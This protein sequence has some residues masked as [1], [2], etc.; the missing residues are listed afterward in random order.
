MGALETTNRP[1]AA[2]GTGGTTRGVLERLEVFPVGT[3]PYFQHEVIPKNIPKVDVWRFIN[4]LRSGV[5]R[6]EAED[7]VMQDWRRRF[8]LGCVARVTGEL[9]RKGVAPVL[10]VELVTAW[11]G[12]HFDL[13]ADDTM[14]CI[15]WVAQRE[16]Q[17]RGGEAG[18]GTSSERREAGR[19]A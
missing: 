7:I 1:A 2:P 17:R 4:L 9:F 13:D 19:V 10:V 16:L 11:A 18:V 8:G 6:E 12:A 5:P 3:L 15:D 14:S